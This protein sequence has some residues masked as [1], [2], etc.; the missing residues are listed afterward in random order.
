MSHKTAAKKE[1]RDVIITADKA[2]YKA[3]ENGRNRCEKIMV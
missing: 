1:A 2:L 3:K